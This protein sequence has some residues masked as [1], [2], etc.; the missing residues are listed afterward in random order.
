M[1]RQEFIR[2]SQSFRNRSAV[3]ALGIL[4]LMI[5]SLI[6]GSRIVDGCRDRPGFRTTLLG[7][8][9]FLFLASA[10]A[11]V[12]YMRRLEKRMGLTC[13]HCHKGIAGISTV[14]IA[15]ANCGHCG[16]TVFDAA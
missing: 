5:G 7:I 13:P 8:S 16:E 12:I 9:I 14:V 6:L 3:G 2:R 4:A 11:M 15:T 1:T 10:P